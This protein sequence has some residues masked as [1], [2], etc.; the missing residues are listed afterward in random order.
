MAK[1]ICNYDLIMNEY[2]ISNGLDH[3]FI[4]KTLNFIETDHFYVIVMEYVPGG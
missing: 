2:Q 4:T 1:S 3:P